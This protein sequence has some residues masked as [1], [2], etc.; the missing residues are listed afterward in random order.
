MFEYNTKGTCS[1]KIHFDIKDGK[2]RNV[3]FEKGCDGN[4]KALSSLVEGMD[5]EEVIS[6]LKGIRC[7]GKATSCGHQFSLAL[8]GAPK[9]A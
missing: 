8:M 7:G 6:R 5:V 9:N 2:V 3:S 4:L 1:K